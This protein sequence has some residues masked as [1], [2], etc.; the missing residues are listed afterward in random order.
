MLD[1]VVRRRDIER[2][3]PPAGAFREVAYARG[4]VPAFLTRSLGTFCVD[5]PD[6]V[7]SLTYDDG[8]DP[9]TTPGVLDAL[10]RH[11]ATATFFVLSEPARRHPEIVRRIVAEG[12]ELALHG[13][14]HTSLLTMDDD[15]AVATIRE[16][17]DVV[18][19][20]AGTAVR[21]Y[22]PPYGEHTWGQAR[23]VRRLG[24]ELTI[25]SGDAFDWVHDDEE[26]VAARALSSV[27]PGA[28]LLLHDTRADP[29][30][31]GPG[32]RLP[33]FDRADV[34]DRILTAT[35]AQGYAEATTGAL[36]TRYRRVRSLARERMARR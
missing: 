23:G 6:R 5:T 19:E 32:E 35:R 14:D 33:E 36:T 27:F 20:V 12:H 21:L 1:L 8:P 7:Y 22:R 11:G 25:W 3:D 15:V 2:E 26:A 16:A 28:I 24:L 13:K 31:L 10:A 29:E 18:E 4:L 30:T 17:R 9:R 34:L